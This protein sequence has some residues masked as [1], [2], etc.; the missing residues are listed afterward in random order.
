VSSNRFADN[1]NDSDERD[2]HSERGTD[3][4][5]AEIDRTRAEMDHTVEAL[6]AR[7]DPQAMVR[8]CL[9]SLRENAGEVAQRGLTII[10]AN[11]IP[12]AL[13]G[14]GAAWLIVDLTRKKSSPPSQ[15]SH[16]R[17][18]ERRSA[19]DV[20]MP[21]DVCIQETRSRVSMAALRD[22]QGGSGDPGGSESFERSHS[23]THGS[24]TRKINQKIK[25]TGREI[26]SQA[27]HR[28]QDMRGYVGEKASQVGHQLQYGSSRA[29]DWF[30]QTVDEYPLAVGAAFFTLGL[31]GGIMIPATRPEN[32]YLGKTRDRLFNQAQEY[33]S[34]LIDKGQQA[35]EHLV[36]SVR[37]S[38]S[39]SD[40]SDSET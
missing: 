14:I 32:R 10:K 24:H 15:R 11:P 27:M 13:I 38:V 28:M 19:T 39:T 12:A 18:I 40:E 16:R 1:L 3:V 34:E 8:Q 23:S 4:I 7:L 36:Q 5:R 17:Q 37:E 6:Q 26:R 9:E 29:K 21:V 2:D 33:G 31:I 20:D 30:E 22:E 25:R 35:A